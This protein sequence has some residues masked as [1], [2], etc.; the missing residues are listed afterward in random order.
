[1]G[2]PGRG[3][4]PHRGDLAHPETGDY[5]SVNTYAN[6][7]D[8]KENMD[9]CAENFAFVSDRVKCMKKLN[10]RRPA[11]SCK[12]APP[13]FLPR[14]IRERAHEKR[15]AA[16]PPILSLAYVE[17]CGGPVRRALGFFNWWL[18]LS[19]CS[20]R[21]QLCCKAWAAE[22]ERQRSREVLSRTFVLSSTSVLSSAFKC[23]WGGQRVASKSIARARAREGYVGGAGARRGGAGCG[24]SRAG[25]EVLQ[26][27]VPVCAD[28]GASGVGVGGIGLFI[29]TYTLLHS[30]RGPGNRGC[31]AQSWWYRSE[32]VV[33][34]GSTLSGCMQRL[35][36]RRE[37]WL[38]YRYATGSV[39][40]TC[41]YTA[42]TRR[43]ALSSSPF[44][45]PPPP[46][47]PP[48]STVAWRDRG[49]SPSGT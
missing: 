32:L 33:V 9:W 40:C 27:W 39:A 42:G 8:N 25:A 22:L 6:L 38:G 10:V 34:R 28:G 18:H 36:A 48:D 7:V 19:F 5:A 45:L 15:Y 1:M 49:E 37:I 35:R 12:H 21:G 20:P 13:P 46:P 3:P 23:W 26:G 4:G 2:V 16:Q 47:P 29:T 14:A 43:R 44:P 30:S 17:S 24:F 41:M 31:I 11:R